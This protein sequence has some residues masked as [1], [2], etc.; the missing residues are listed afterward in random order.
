MHTTTPLFQAQHADRT[1]VLRLARSA[2]ASK[3]QIAFLHVC[4]A[5][6]YTCCGDLSR[7]AS[8]V[9]SSPRLHESLMY[10]SLTSDGCP[11]LLSVLAVS[12]RVVWSSFGR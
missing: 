11:G 4:N 10:A 12:R 7:L 3:L 6:I 2:N 9:G 5:N 1:R 8:L